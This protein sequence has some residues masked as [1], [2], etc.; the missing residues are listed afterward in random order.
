[1]ADAPV[2]ESELLLLGGV[3]TPA[4]RSS[5]QDASVVDVLVP[6]RS[7]GAPT[8]ACVVAIVRAATHTTPERE[9]PR[10]LMMKVSCSFSMG[11]LIPAVRS[12]RQDTLVVDVLV[13][14]RSHGTPTC[15]CVVA[16]VRAAT[17]HNS[18]AGDTTNSDADGDQLL[19]DEADDKVSTEF[20]ARHE[21]R[22]RVFSLKARYRCVPRLLWERKGVIRGIAPGDC[23]EELDHKIVNS[24]NTLTLGAKRIKS[25]GTVFVVFDRYKVPN[26]GSYGGTLV[27]CT[28]YRKQVE[29][30]YACGRLGH[31]ADV[32]PSPDEA[33]C[34][35][36]GAANP[37]E[38]HKCDPKCRLCGGRHFTAA[39]EC[40]QR[41]QTA[42][43]VRR[44]R[45]ERSRANRSKSLAFAKGE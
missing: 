29:V 7:H 35:G 26:Y 22:V 9:T 6:G 43:L 23:P 40:K 25:T 42:Y 32:C 44:R 38:Q 37:N 12:S 1:M 34:K 17:Q 11:V 27:K 45:G 36:C 16:I 20:H 15:A 5:R 10:I 13:P 31:R 2:D 21:A 41:Y 30:C 39:K 24:K 4:V 18:R 14:G 33:V 3:L 28:L 19:V 8:C